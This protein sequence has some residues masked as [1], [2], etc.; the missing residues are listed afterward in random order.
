LSGPPRSSG[1]LKPSGTPKPNDAPK[2]GG[3]PKQSARDVAGRALAR[4]WQKDAFAS[5]ALDAELALARLDPRDAALATELCYGVLRTE[6]WLLSK[7][8]KVT[9]KF[10]APAGLVRA[11]LLMGAFAICFLDR[12]PAFAAVAEAVEAARRV[13]DPKVGG[14]VN[15]VLRKLAAAV[16]RDGRPSLASAVAASCPPWLSAALGRAIGKDAVPAFLTEGSATPPLG[17]CVADPEGRA[18]TI[19]GLR[20]AVP[21]G[22]FEPGAVSP[23]AILVRGAGDPRRLPGLGKDFIVQEE[24]AQVVALALGA[25]PGERVL[26]ACA[27]HGNKTWLLCHE[28]G[29]SGQADAADLHRAKLHALENAAPKGLPRPRAFQVDW[30]A[31]RGEVPVGYDRVLVDAPCSGT[32]TLRRRPEI[33]LRR[34]REDVQRLAELQV[35][36]L[37]HTAACVRNGGRLVYAV[38]S[39]LREEAED[40]VAAAV[41]KGGEGGEELSP[42]PFDAPAALAL[43]GEA[44]SFRLLTH[45]HGTDGYFVASLIVR[46][47]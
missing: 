32:G 23:R 33:A 24:G 19:E 45:V 17:L 5:A 28:V 10:R 39:V 15:A 35:S 40:V 14:F 29:A 34:T 3:A 42:A 30:S 8:A 37:R 31:S 47:T 16:E 46:R 18:A 26:D 13:A 21:E 11:H 27:G 6:P 2:P 1:T 12:V 38:C 36:I 4:V 25:R 7:L 9:G 41:A 43:A 20:A 22:S 44:P